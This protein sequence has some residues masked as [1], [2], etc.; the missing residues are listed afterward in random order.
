MLALAEESRLDGSVALLVHG[1]VDDDTVEQFEMGLDSVLADEPE[2]LVLDLTDCRLDSAGLAA[3]VRV[4]RRRRDRPSV[5]RLVATD[6]DLLRLLEIVGLMPG[7]RVFESLDAA[8]RPHRAT[9]LAVTAGVADA[10]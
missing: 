6:V 7:L 1:I 10:Y 4:E 9:A 8:L 3:L 5:T 2:R